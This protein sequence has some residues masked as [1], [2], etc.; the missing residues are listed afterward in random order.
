MPGN[1]AGFVLIGGQRLNRSKPTTRG[2]DDKETG[3]HNDSGKQHEHD[4]VGQDHATR[5]RIKRKQGVARP[6]H[7][8]GCH[9]TEGSHLGN[10]Q[11]HSPG[12]RQQIGGQP[13]H[14]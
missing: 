3:D 11:R 1:D 7:Q 5:A 10:N 9:L 13:S 4:R 6:N 8:Y 2:I 14:N 12:H